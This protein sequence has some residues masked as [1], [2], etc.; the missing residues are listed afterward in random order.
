MRNFTTLFCYTLSIMLGTF[1]YTLGFNS[2]DLFM[3]LV[4]CGVSGGLMTI[5]FLL[6]Y[7]ILNGENENERST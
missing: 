4:L 3:A 1:M 6:M 2:E 7:K 5:T